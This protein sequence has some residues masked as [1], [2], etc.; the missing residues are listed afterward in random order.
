M[1]LKSYHEVFILIHHSTIL[2]FTPNK[3]T[4]PLALLASCDLISISQSCS[5]FLLVSCVLISSDL[6]SLP[7]LVCGPPCTSAVLS[8]WGHSSKYRQGD[9]LNYFR[10]YL[11]W[12][13]GLLPP[14]YHRQ[15]WCGSWQLPSLLIGRH[16][17][18]LVT[19]LNHHLSL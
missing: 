12:W 6:I 19:S 14:L 8:F 15:F 17:S 3:K 2:V 11:T 16:G 9:L 1:R 18:V 4:I 13:S 7:V 5:V 10:W